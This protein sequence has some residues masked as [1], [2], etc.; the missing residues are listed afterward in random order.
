MIAHIKRKQKGF[1]YFCV[2]IATALISPFGIAFVIQNFKVTFAWL[3]AAGKFI[4]SDL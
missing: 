2:C 3:S 4:G 1:L